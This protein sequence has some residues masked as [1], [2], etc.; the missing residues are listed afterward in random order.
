MP[1]PAATTATG[2]KI[3]VAGVASKKTLTRS[4]V[5]RKSRAEAKNSETRWVCVVMG[6]LLS[7]IA[8]E[9]DIG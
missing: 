5:A 4:A 1:I 7:G 9:Y 3:R 8:L 2:P 6:H